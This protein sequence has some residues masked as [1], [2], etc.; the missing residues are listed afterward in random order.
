M[1]ACT[2]QVSVLDD[3]KRGWGP[4]CYGQL[5]MKTASRMVRANVC[6]YPRMFRVYAFAV[7]GQ[8]KN[9]NFI[10]AHSKTP[11]WLSSH[12]EI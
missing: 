2:L 9:L 10:L 1:G 8:I 3:I 12:M 5:E 7:C 6:R 11:I 4:F